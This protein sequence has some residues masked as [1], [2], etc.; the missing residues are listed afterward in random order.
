[1]TMAER[2]NTARHPQ[3]AVRK[4]ASGRDS[5][6]PAT[7]PAMILPMTWPS[8][9]LRRQVHG[10]W[11]KDLATHG[12]DAEGQRRHEESWRCGAT[13]HRDQ[14]EHRAPPW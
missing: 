5:M 6:M 7:S 10:E 12:A 13:G 9:L 1:M 3:C 8:Q 14:A 2:T 11:D 4:L